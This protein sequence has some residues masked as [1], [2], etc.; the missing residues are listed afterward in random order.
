MVA[1]LLSSGELREGVGRY[2]SCVRELCV[3]DASCTA[4]TL[5]VW[6][7]GARAPAPP[8][9]SVVLLRGVRPR[10]GTVAKGGRL[11]GGGGGGDVSAGPL[12]RRER[13]GTPW[14][15]MLVSADE[16][17]TK[18]VQSRTHALTKSFRQYALAF[19]LTLRT[20]RLR[21]TPTPLNLGPPHTRPPHTTPRA[22]TRA[23]AR[24]HTHTRT[25]A[26]YRHHDL[27]GPWRGAQ[28][29]HACRMRAKLSLSCCRGH[30]ACARFSARPERAVTTGMGRLQLEGTCKTGCGR[31]RS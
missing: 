8:A 11:Y 18:C 24:T 6:G 13:G 2:A 26:T 29:M 5:S 10:T 9:G 17:L 7:A 27:E 22:R 25:H 16:E 20:W 19:S 14:I 15:E 23:R 21:L 30:G 4:A 28:S 1:V 31:A 12:A 3:G